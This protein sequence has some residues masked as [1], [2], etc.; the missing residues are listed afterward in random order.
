MGEEGWLSI[1]GDD[2]SSVI[3]GSL[4][5]DSRGTRLGQ[6]HGPSCGGCRV[7]KVFIN[8]VWIIFGP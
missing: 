5:L 1:V 2:D 6:M 7:R 8:N 4:R 3:V